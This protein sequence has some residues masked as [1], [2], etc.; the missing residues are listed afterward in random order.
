MEGLP[1]WWW[2]GAQALDRPSYSWGSGGE[3][4]SPPPH[5]LQVVLLLDTCGSASQLSPVQMR[6]MEE[7]SEDSQD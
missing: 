5:T 2:E 1:S 6:R 3:T 7:L 4:S